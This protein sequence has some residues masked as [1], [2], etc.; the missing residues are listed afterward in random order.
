MATKK[1]TKKTAAKK[2]PPGT[3]LERI[4]DAA[5]D[6]ALAVG[7][8][9]V[10]MEAVAGRA[11]MNLGDVLLEAPNKACLL[12]KFIDQIDERT[13]R[14]V[15]AAA[16]ETA[17]DRMFE[18]LMRRFDAMN[19]RRE[20]AKAVI[21]GVARDPASALIGMCRLRKSFV[22]MLE[23]AGV[24]TSGPLG[25]L[26]VAGLKAVA[27]AALRAWMTDDSADLSKTMAA[28]DRALDRAEKLA[29]MARWRG[30]KTEDAEAA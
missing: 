29:G 15:K 22:L 12:V 23:A 14:P 7:W 9:Q 20:E 28:L 17:R 2:A 21:T 5:L 3:P 4:I 19:A 13:I 18:I 27:A 11:G 10:S 24:N 6:E 8:R 16:D 25:C 1:S 30:R 26:R